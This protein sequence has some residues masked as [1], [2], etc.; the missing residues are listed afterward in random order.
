MNTGYI[1][2]TIFV[3]SSGKVLDSAYVGSR[4]YASWAAIIDGYLK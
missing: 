4:D 1:P 2:T 3:D